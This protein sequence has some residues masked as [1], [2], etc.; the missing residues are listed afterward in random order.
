MKN[1][2]KF[3]LGLLLVLVLAIFA[4]TAMADSVG[5]QVIGA[6]ISEEGE[7]YKYN[8]GV[9]AGDLE[10]EYH[11]NAGTYVIRKPNGDVVGGGKQEE[12]SE[13]FFA[14]ALSLLGCIDGEMTNAICRSVPIIQQQGV[15]HHFFIGVQSDGKRLRIVDIGHGKA[16]RRRRHIVLL[17]R[18]KLER[19]CIGIIF[20]IDGLDCNFHNAPLSYSVSS[21]VSSCTSL[22]SSASENSRRNTDCCQFKTIFVCF[23]T[24]CA[25]AVIQSESCISAS[26]VR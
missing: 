22:S 14:I 11:A 20:G 9:G 19:Q 7:G 18:Q 16:L 5:A 21:A 13:G 24:A 1:T 17:L 6:E 10:A 8:Y 2:R 3:L 12:L 23:P 25:A 26:R 15:A 4:C